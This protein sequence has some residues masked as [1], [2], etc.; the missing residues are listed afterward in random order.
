MHGYD[1]DTCSFTALS[2]VVT[3]AEEIKVSPSSLF[4]PLHKAV[5]VNSTFTIVQ[6]VEDS[7]WE[8]FKLMHVGYVFRSLNDCLC[9]TWMLYLS[10]S[11]FH[12]EGALYVV[13]AKTAMG[14]MYVHFLQYITRTGFYIHLVIVLSMCIY[15]VSDFSFTSTNIVQTCYGWCINISRYESDICDIDQ[16]GKPMESMLALFCGHIVSAV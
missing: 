12:T 8:Y 4:F 9:L 15:T 10:F 7:V 3:N 5:F 14:K 13:L 16:Q 1:K 6:R 11:V 2:Q